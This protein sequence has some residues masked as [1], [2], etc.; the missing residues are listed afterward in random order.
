MICWIESFVIYSLTNQRKILFTV[1][2]WWC[3]CPVVHILRCTYLLLH[4]K[5][6]EQQWIRQQ[7]HL[8]AKRKT[9]INRPTPG[10]K[11]KK[12]P[13]FLSQQRQH[14]IRLR[15]ILVI[16]RVNY[17]SGI[18]SLNNRLVIVLLK[19]RLFSQKKAKLFLNST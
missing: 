18:L 7:Q 12:W 16:I 10:N 15:S 2:G 6:T 9:Q 8:M 4:Q 17:L 3:G 1:L 14:S 11:E 5:N 13:R 19:E